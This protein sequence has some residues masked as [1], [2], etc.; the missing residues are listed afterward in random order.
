MSYQKI[1]D[2]I[3][4]YNF[5]KADLAKIKAEKQWIVLEKIHGANFSINY[6]RDTKNITFCKRNGL[7]KDNEWFY[8]YHII[9][10]YLEK[11]IVKLNDILADHSYEQ[12]TVY[13][14]LFGGSYPDIKSRIRAVQE[15]V[16]YSDQLHFFAY[17]ICLNNDTYLPFDIFT[18]AIE[19]SGFEYAKPLLI[20][21]SYE[22]AIYF[23]IK[24]DSKISEQLK[25]PKL[26]TNIMEGVV[27]KP[28]SNIVLSNGNRCL[29]KHK[30]KEFLEYSIDLTSEILNDYTSIFPMLLNK[31][32]LK[33]AESK[34]GI[35]TNDTFDTILEEMANDMFTDGYIYK[36][37]I[38]IDDYD[39]VM[40]FVRSLLTDYLRLNMD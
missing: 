17:D 15:G 7:L 16:Y 24:I 4:R 36:P 10:E 19:D 31:N 28:F 18:R 23:D 2:S 30:N 40:K 1:Y 9:K 21:D 11:C 34:I 38:I 22:E 26:L 20:C 13:G 35:L 25:M 39:E 14:E 12:I 6:N 3:S 32:R 37:S 29:I 33:S 8:N 5:S 27:I